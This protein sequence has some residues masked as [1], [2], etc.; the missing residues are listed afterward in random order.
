MKLHSLTSLVF[1][2]SVLAN[3]GGS[4]SSI[5]SGFNPLGAPGGNL[6]QPYTVIKPGG[7]KAGTYITTANNSTPFF[8]QRPGDGSTAESLL[9]AG[10][11]MRVVKSDSS[12]VKVEL[13][14]GKV[15]Y[16]AVAMVN[17]TVS[18]S[19]AGSQ[20]PSVPVI[21]NPNLNVPGALPSSSLELPSVLRTT[22]PTTGAPVPPINPPGV[23]PL[24]ASGEGLP[25][26]LGSGS[27]PPSGAALP[28]SSAER[29]R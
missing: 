29:S 25:P 13:D 5:D 3:C 14:D 18:T 7:F 8:R 15:G 21:A 16:V 6:G 11:M 17:P 12:F 9:P 2:C 26:S 24:P 27:L 23:A 4:H 1:L 10:T 28:P 20:L 19:A 22:D